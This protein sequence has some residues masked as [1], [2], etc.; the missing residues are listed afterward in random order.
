MV[1]SPFYCTV[2]NQTCSIVLF[3]PQIDDVEAFIIIFVEYE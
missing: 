3:L 2:F 1:E